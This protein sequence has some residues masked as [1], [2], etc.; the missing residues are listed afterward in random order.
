MV[1]EME[2]RMMDL[3]KLNP[4]PHLVRGL[5]YVKTRLGEGSTWVS[6]GASV[7][8]VSALTPP[9]SYIGLACGVMAAMV[10]NRKACP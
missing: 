9:W 10:P 3:C 1:G 6:I 4:I 8:A 2:R 5:S 7:A